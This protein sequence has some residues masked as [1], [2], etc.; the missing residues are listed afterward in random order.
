MRASIAS[1]RS[2]F[3]FLPP[4][5]SSPLPSRS[6]SSI[7]KLFAIS[8]RIFS[9]TTTA[10]IFASSP[11]LFSGKFLYRSVTQTAPKMES[12]KNS[13]RSLLNLLPVSLETERCIKERFNKS[14]LLNLKP[15]A[16]WK[17]A[18]FFFLSEL[19]MYLLFLLGFNKFVCVLYGFKFIGFF[20]RNV[21][22][23]FFFYSIN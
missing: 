22:A 13:R 2:A 20:I 3:L 5:R 23:H 19:R 10:F 1:A 21:N 18:S 8:E 15:A 12:P 4:E 6:I 9:E 11:S 17:T 14:R 16:F 7:F